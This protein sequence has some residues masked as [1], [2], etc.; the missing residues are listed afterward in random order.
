M[1]IYDLGDLGYFYEIYCF[2]IYSVLS[3][4]NNFLSFSVG[5]LG[6]NLTSAHTLVFMEHDWNP[7]RDQV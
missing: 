3:S 5:G 6:L 4:N 1:F 2:N 7:M